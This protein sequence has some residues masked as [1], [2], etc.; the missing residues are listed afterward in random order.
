[1]RP[2]TNAIDMFLFKY[3]GILPPLFLIAALGLQ[4]NFA[5]FARG[6]GG[7]VD[8][9]NI[10]LISFGLFG[11]G[12][13]IFAIGYAG[14][15]TSGR[16]IIGHVAD[17][18]NTTGIYSICRNPLYLGNFFLWLA[19]V[20]ALDSVP[21]IALFLIAFWWFYSRIIQS[22]EAFLMQKFGT[23]YSDYHARTWRILPNILTYRRG[24]TRFDMMRVFHQESGGLLAFFTAFIISDKADILLG[25]EFAPLMEDV[26]LLAGFGLSFCLYGFLRCIKPPKK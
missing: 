24:Q 13:R 9:P 12:I 17:S 10:A 20:M 1:M 26:I 14:K 15:N 11:M 2:Q 18:L 25:G 22:E 3:R 4:I 8:L 21:I 19:C 7:W 16:N 6:A 23:E 5:V